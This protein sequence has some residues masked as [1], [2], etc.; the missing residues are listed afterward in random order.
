MKPT[1]F[2]GHT[3]FMNDLTSSSMRE[4]K[5]S[6]FAEKTTGLNYSAEDIMERLLSAKERNLISRA[7][8]KSLTYY[9]SAGSYLLSALQAYETS[10]NFKSFLPFAQHLIIRYFGPKDDS[11]FS[12]REE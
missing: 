7:M 2:A 6:G 11:F 5:P 1:P 9:E 10:T 8:D 4:D 12:E 3:G